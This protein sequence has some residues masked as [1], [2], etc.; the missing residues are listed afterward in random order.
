M[1]CDP[2]ALMEQAKCLIRCIPPGM[3]P[4][5][6]VALLCQL[7]GGAPGTGG[8]FVL[9]AGDTM[10]G[11]LT[12]PNFVSTGPVGFGSPV[13]GTVQM[14]VQDALNTT[15]IFVNNVKTP[16]GAAGSG[17]NSGIILRSTTLASYGWNLLT[18]GALD[19]LE[20]Q[21]EGVA[22][23]AIFTA[24]KNL[25]LHT[26]ST[27]QPASLAK[28]IVLAD[29]TAASADPTTASAIWSVGGALQYRT[30]GTGE[31]SGQTNR[32]HNF[33]LSVYATGTNYT[34]TNATAAVVFGTTSPIITLTAPG[35][36]RITCICKLNT[37]GASY[38][39]ATNAN[40][41][42]SRTNN[43]PADLPGSDKIIT[44]PVMTTDTRTVCEVT[45]DVLYTT[46]LST[47]TIQPFAFVDTLPSAGTIKVAAA[48]IV[49]VRLS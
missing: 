17:G 31:G 14:T 20:I 30:S 26:V 19:Q 36:Y 2:N 41:K 7:A 4:A 16:G 48:Q 49:A 40:F 33:G 42:L 25:I 18:N 8:L 1:A 21:D 24:Q 13:V 5:V 27:V 10:T 45:M 32:L 47:D 3:M 46:V 37:A 39:G 29:G 35:T 28:G 15:F 34:M 22:T 11:L 9:K 38:V 12:A 43:T 44:I 23:M 6:E